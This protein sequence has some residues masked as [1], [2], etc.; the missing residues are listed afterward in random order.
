M[1]TTQA[2]DAVLVTWGDRL[3]DPRNRIV[4]AELSPRLYGSIREK[5]AE[6][7]QRVRAIVVHQAPQAILRISG[8]G[9]GMRTIARHFMY[10]SRNGRLEVEDDRGLRHTGKDSLRDL[11]DQWRYG[12][13]PIDQISSR[14]EAFN[15][16]LST[17][18]GTDPKLLLQAVREFAKA[19][20]SAH[21]YVMALHEDRG[22]PHVHLTVRAQSPSGQRLQTWTER[23]RWRTV[24]AGKLRE[25]G[26]EV[27][28]TRQSTRGE[29]RNFETLGRLK[30]KSR[31][32]LRSTKPATKTGEAFARNGAEAM[33]SWAHLIKALAVSESAEDRQLATDIA[34]FVRSTPFYREAVRRRERQTAMTTRE[35]PGMSTQPRR[36]RM[37]PGPEFTR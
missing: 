28:A 10:I 5:A 20:L 1:M 11:L 33:Q 31:G 27:E 9:R 21:R 23:E 16:V 6:Y 12:G 19:E 13:A 17:P 8:G 25:L 3:F 22:H 32:E 26:V 2:V 34:V 24:Y 35:V 4:K 7:R 14:R 37:R 18:A 30:V 36:D 29:N 15:F